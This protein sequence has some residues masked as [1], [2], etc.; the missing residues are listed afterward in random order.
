MKLPGPGAVGSALRAAQ[1]TAGAVL[2]DFVEER[3]DDPLDERDPAFIEATLPVYKLLVDAY[4]RPKVRGLE[5]IPKDGP[6]LLVGNHSGGT[7]IVD[8]FAFSDHF[9]A[10]FGTSRRF[11]A[12]AHD[13]V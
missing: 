4:F 1:V 5:L 11:H 9:H 2:R 8:T 13:L 7:L 3:A 10:Y 12:L 6:V